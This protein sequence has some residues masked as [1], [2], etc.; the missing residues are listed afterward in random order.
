[1][2]R[3][4]QLRPGQQSDALQRRLDPPG[5]DVRSS[6][7]SRWPRGWAQKRARYLRRTDSAPPGSSNRLQDSR[8]VQAG[9][10]R[11]PYIRKHP[12]DSMAWRL[13]SRISTSR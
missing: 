7:R 10:Q 1:M 5:Q 8:V 13:T 6:G 11:T 4:V 2:R 12:D 9:S 3:V